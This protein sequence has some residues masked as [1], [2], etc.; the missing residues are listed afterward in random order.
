MQ[1]SLASILASLLA[2]VSVSVSLAFFVQ[3]FLL[4]YDSYVATS[5]HIKVRALPSLE[6]SHTDEEKQKE[7]EEK[8]ASSASRLS[9]SPMGSC[10]SFETLKL[11]S[12]S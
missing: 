10:P 4:V 12:T 8:S 7:E 2:S 9:V 6:R 5:S 1:Y 3:S 11:C